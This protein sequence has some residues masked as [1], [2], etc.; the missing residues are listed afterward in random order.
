MIN[1]GTITIE[2]ERLILRKAN[3]S[4]VP[5]MYANWT[6]DS[7][8]T[9]FLTW[10]AHRSVSD[11]EGFVNGFLLKNYD[12]L[13]FY[14]WVMELKE[15]AQAVGMI[16]VVNIDESIECLR[17]GYCLGRKW[18]NA[19]IM[20]EALGAVIRFLF[21]EV[22]VNRIEAHHDVNNPVSGK[23]MAK[24]GMSY[25]GTM[26][27]AGKNNQPDYCDLACY[28]VLRNDYCSN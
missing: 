7:E 23:V 21:D 9:Q 6:S 4:D 24:C 26:R 14:E 25:E 2:T 16:S 20:T 1:K 12:R 19:N 28:A 10:P 3:L 15:I 22:K 27:Q 11:T 18:W 13:D 17:V 8:V 5:H